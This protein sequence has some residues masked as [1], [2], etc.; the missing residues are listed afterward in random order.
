M[1]IA[2]LL[3]KVGDAATPR[4]Y[5]ERV[6]EILSSRA[7]GASI[8]LRYNG[9]ND[10]GEVTAGGAARAGDVETLTVTDAEGRR[11]ELAMTGAP[12]GLPLPELRAE[13]EVANQLAVL[14]GRRTALERERRL[15]TFLVELSRWLLAAPETELLLRYTLMSLTKLVEAQGAYV[16]L[17]EGDEPLRVATAVGRAQDLQNVT[18]PVEAST[19]GRVTRTGQPLVT[20]DITA[21]PDS[22][23]GAI[24]LAADARAAMIAPLQTSH[25][26]IGAVAVIRYLE[27]DG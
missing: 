11:V 12:M 20:E 7:G 17:R 6:A 16:A 15:G 3:A 1:P 8:H 21:E 22:H 27:T 25:G 24:A 14:V 26:V 10:S 13:L 19:T 23:P 9:L 5:W 4:E 2:E 18:F